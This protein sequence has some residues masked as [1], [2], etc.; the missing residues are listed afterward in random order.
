MSKLNENQKKPR[1]IAVVGPTASGKTALSIEL[2]KIYNGEIISCD[3]MQIYRGMDIGTAKPTEGEKCGIPHHMIDIIEPCE[4]FSAADYSPLAKAAADD[5]ISRGKM[6][7]F[8]GGTGLYLDAVLKAND[9]A[10]VDT[11]PALRAS[12]MEDAER[13]GAHEIWLKLQSVDP[14]AAA[15]T[16]ENNVKRVVRALELYLSSGVTKTE[17]DKRSR[18]RPTPYDATVI[19]L[20]RER[21]K[22]YER[23]DMRVDIMM[24]Q[25]LE[26]EVR[27]LIESGRLPRSS[28]AAQAIGYKEFIDYI[29]GNATLPESVEKIKQSTR[30]YAKRQLTW[31]RRDTAVNWINADANFKDIVNNAEKLLT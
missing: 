16:H 14:E 3:S 9:Y 24:Q 30:R 4:A 6:P 10:D 28:T 29:D 5:I 8:C 1:V 13:L 11:D 17:W 15:A 22:M 20:E 23:I 26:N 2:A 25:G 19:A 21:D 12:L 27:S 18:L 7:I 31:F